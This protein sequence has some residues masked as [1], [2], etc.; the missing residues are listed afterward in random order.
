MLLLLFAGGGVDVGES[1]LL[2]GSA[3]TGDGLG[4]GNGEGE[5]V[6]T[7]GGGVL[8][9]M[10]ASA[11]EGRGAGRVGPVSSGD[12]AALFGAAFAS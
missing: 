12:A 9:D 3:T 10:S 5:T 8:L 1:A 2:D 7:L 6:D 11:S 4:E